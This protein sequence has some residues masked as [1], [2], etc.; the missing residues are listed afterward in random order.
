MH[1]RN[2]AQT[3][4]D[5]QGSNIHQVEFTNFRTLVKINNI[6]THDSELRGQEEPA[7]TE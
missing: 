5:F 1:M 6:K 2:R 3:N 4:L 7:T